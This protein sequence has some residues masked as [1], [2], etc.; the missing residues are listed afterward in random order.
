MADVA[1]KWKNQTL[2]EMSD[3]GS[4]TLKTAGKYLDADVIVEYAKSGG[5]TIYT[6]LL[7][8]LSAVTNTL[9][10]PL[11]AKC[12]RLLLYADIDAL[13]GAERPGVTTTMANFRT[14]YFNKINAKTGTGAA[15]PIMFVTDRDFAGVFQSSSNG[16]YAAVNNAAFNGGMSAVF[17]STAPYSCTIRASGSGT[18]Y[19]F[20]KLQYRYW[21]WYEEGS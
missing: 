3:T 2:A 7:T 9:T 5:T 16:S 11:P 10:I 18:S 19:N 20:G 4:K 6:G 14:A 13:L 1:I 8:A 15:A 17:T 12:N 21:A